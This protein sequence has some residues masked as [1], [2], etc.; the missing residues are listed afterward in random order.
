MTRLFRLADWV[1][2]KKSELLTFGDDDTPF[3]SVSI[4]LCAGGPTE[5]EVMADGTSVPVQIEGGL[6]VL[7]FS[8]SGKVGLRFAGPVAYLTQ[9][10]TD[11]RIT[12]KDEP[13]YT[14]IANRKARNADMEWMLYKMEENQRNMRRMLENEYE[15]RIAALEEGNFD[16]ETG[17]EGRKRR[18][19]DDDGGADRGD[20]QRADVSPG[21]ARGAEA[22]DD[23]A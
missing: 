5:A 18:S 10:G 15:A 19:D 3:R 21:R 12:A 22:Q 23:A 16:Y 4:R 17:E 11:L 13:T 20:E 8:A 6:D 1:R 2:V 7:E 14:K 9:E